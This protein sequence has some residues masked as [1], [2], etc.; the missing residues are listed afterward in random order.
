MGLLEGL[1]PLLAPGPIVAFVVCALVEEIK[2]TELCNLTCSP[3][4]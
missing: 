3:S 1:S 2:F 4:V